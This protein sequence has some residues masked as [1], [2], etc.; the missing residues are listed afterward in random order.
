MFWILC[1]GWVFGQWEQTNGLYRVQTNCLFSHGDYIFV[2]TEGAGLYRS[3]DEGFS[4]ELLSQGLPTEFYWMEMAADSQFIYAGIGTQVYKSLDDGLTWSPAASFPTQPFTGIYRL[5]SFSGKLFAATNKG[6][7]ISNDTGDS[8]KLSNSGLPADLWPGVYDLAAIDDQL[9]CAISTKGIFR[10]DDK[11]ATWVDI[12]ENLP[13]QDDQNISL[14]VISGYLYA[15]TGKHGVFS[16]PPSSTNWMEGNT[17]LVNLEVFSLLASD[18][19]SPRLY[20][21]TRVGVF[22]SYGDGNWYQLGS[23]LDY[24]GNLGKHGDYLFAGSAF[25]NLFRLLGDWTAVSTGIINSEIQQLA[26]TPEAVLAFHGWGEELFGQSDDQGAHWT[27][28]PGGLY[29]LQTLTAYD[30]TFW[31]GT[32]EGVFFSTDGGWTWDKKADFQ[33]VTAFAFDGGAVYACQATDTTSYIRISYDNGESWPA[34]RSLPVPN[35]WVEDLLVLDNDIV[36]M[37]TNANG[38]LVSHDGGATWNYGEEGFPGNCSGLEHCPV[39]DAARVGNK[40]FAALYNEGLFVSEDA[41]DHW[42]A[43]A[44]FPESSGAARIFFHA[45]WLFVSTYNKGVFIS[46]DSGAIWLAFNE[47]LETF[48][49]SPL[50]KSFAADETYLYAGIANKGVWRRKFPSVTSSNTLSQPSKPTIFKVFPRPATYYTQL[51]FT[52]A[53]NSKPVVFN[54]TDLNGKVCRTEIVSSPD[55]IIKRGNLSAGIYFFTLSSDVTVIGFGKIIFV[56]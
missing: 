4:W 47:G 49:F 16:L 42:A 17:G 53:S 31:A 51:Q 10:S 8:W 35:I 33:Y 54:L 5:L 11:G 14:E 28:N 13:M 1:T 3:K 7:Y 2:G 50:L 45:P 36:A 22:Q 19:P 20:A 23:D 12:T 40:F 34:S 41:G 56:D 48:Y 52:K 18:S 21:S 24:V 29:G 43:V 44:S 39:S 27:V 55:F 26:A 32:V 9:Y 6:V 46:P 37:L 15:G 30:G 38:V 25:G